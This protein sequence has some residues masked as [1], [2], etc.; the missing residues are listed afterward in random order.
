MRKS[1]PENLKKKSNS[2]RYNLEENYM[3]PLTF[4]FPHILILEMQS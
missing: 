1:K 3:L 2:V 4:T